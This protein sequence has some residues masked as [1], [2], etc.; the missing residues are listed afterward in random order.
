M[1]VSHP[2]PAKSDISTFELIF[3]LP[4]RIAILL[5]AGVWG[6]GLN[7]HYL[8]LIKIDV[9]SLI[10]YPTRQSPHQKTHHVSTYHLAALLT[11]PLIMSLA[12]FWLITRGSIQSVVTWEI[13]PQLYLL[14]MIVLL[15][16]YHHL[17]RSGRKRFFVTLRRISL[18]GI[19]ETQDGKFG[20]ILLADALTS[21][22]KV[23]AEI[24]VNYCM[25]FS[26]SKSSTAKPDRTCG[27]TYAVPIIVAI[28]SLIRLRQC[29]IE[30]RRVRRH[31]YRPTDGWGGQHLA[32]ALKYSTAFP[33]II[34][35]AWER[36]YNTEKSHILSEAAVSHFWAASCFINSSYSFWWDISKDWDMTLLS[37]ERI[38]PEHPYG[39]RQHRVFYSDSI[40]YTAIVV[41]FILR[42]TWV[43]RLSSGLDKV[44]N[45]ESGIFLLMFLEV[46][47]RWMWIFFRVET[48]WVRNNHGPAADDILLGEYNGK[49]DED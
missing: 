38:K 46:A 26:S 34:F 18:G 30:F 35:T 22:A 25:F 9:P 39:L 19:A 12:L 13:I 1:D 44:N 45:F 47:R 21:Y 15:L 24:F 17:S 36:N 16:P 23:L 49:I 2:P 32:N 43:S 20:D 11:I 10:R 28:P 3:P 40:Y 7:L 31:G 29:F 8:K 4:Y 14:L 27:G 48:E 41:D 5:V 6:W 37:N 42:F 33:V